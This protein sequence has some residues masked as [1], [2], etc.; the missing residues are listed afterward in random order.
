MAGCVQLDI[1]QTLKRKGTFDV[2]FNVDTPFDAFLSNISKEIHPSPELEARYLITT[3]DEGIRLG[4]Y[5]VD[6]Q[7]YSTLFAQSQTIDNSLLASRSISFEKKFKFPFFYFNYSIQ[8]PNIEKYNLIEA[9]YIVN[10]FGT[11]TA[12][13]GNKISSQVVEFPLNQQFFSVEFRDFFLFTILGYH[14]LFG[15]AIILVVA[16]LIGL[17]YFSFRKTHSKN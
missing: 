11:I 3:T 12:T 8:F 17:M 6:P 10:V 13:N 4:F 16:L 7:Q 1:E 2:E 9:K 15:I 5:D 14:P